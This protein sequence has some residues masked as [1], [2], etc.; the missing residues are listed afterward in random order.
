M[1]LNPN[2]SASAGVMP[3]ENEVERSSAQESEEQPLLRSDPVP[4]TWSPP[5]G[6]LLIQ[7]GKFDHNIYTIKQNLTINSNHGQCVSWRI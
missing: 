6:F 4:A 3:H 1:A 7:I 5:P 2:E